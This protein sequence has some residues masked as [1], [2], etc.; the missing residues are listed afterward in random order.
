MRL[1]HSVSKFRSCDLLL[2]SLSALSFLTGCSET[3]TDGTP[4]LS[5][6]P[7]SFK[8][9]AIDGTPVAH[10]SS[11][12]A[13][14]SRGVAAAAISTASAPD[15]QSYF[16]APLKT[17]G[18]GHTLY[19]HPLVS[20]R[21]SGAMAE[22]VADEPLTRGTRIESI[23]Q[24]KQ[25]GVSAIPY[26]NDQAFA[27]A[28]PN[29]LFYNETATNASYG[30]KTAN[31]H[32]WPATDKVA[33]YAYAPIPSPSSNGLTLSSGSTAG[34]PYIDYALPATAENQPDLIVA[35]NK[36]L[37]LASVGTN[38]AVPLTFDHQLT[39]IRFVAG[40][41][42]PKGQI[43]SVG[44]TNIAT[45]GRLSLGGNWTTTA[46]GNYTIS[47]MSL[48]LT[49]SENQDIISGTKTLLMIPQS[50]T[51]DN[52][53]IAITYV[54]DNNTYNLT[55][56]LKGT[57]WDKGQSVVYKVSPHSVS[58]L[59]LGSITFATSWGSNYPK[60]AFAAGDA[61]GIYVADA[62]GLKYSN[63]KLTYSNGKWTSAS[64]VLLPENCR[65]YVYYPYSDKGLA[66]TGKAADDAA[67]F[68]AS[69]ISSWSPKTD[70][71]SAENLNASDLQ[72]AVG[73]VSTTTA[74]TVN[75][76]MSHQ[77]GLAVINLGQKTHYDYRHLST[78]ANFKW[79]HNQYTVTASSAIS[80]SITPYKKAST[81][82]VAIQK[83]A[84]T[85]VY[86]TTSTG[87][88][89]WTKT[90][91]YKLSADKYLAQEATC[92]P[93]NTETSYTMALGDVYYSDGDMSHQSESLISGKTPIGIVG[94]IGSNYWTE[95]NTK[96]SSVGGHALV[97]CLKTIGS[98]GTTNYGTSYQWKTSNTDDN[99]S[100]VNTSALIV[101]SSTQ[102]YGSGYKESVAL[103]NSA[104]PAA[105]AALAYTTLKAPSTSTGWFL[106]TAG[107]YY[108]IM[109]AIGDY[110]SSGW[111][112]SNFVSNMIM[113]DVTTKVNT[114]LS[115]VGANN[116]TEFFQANSTF[117]WTST[118]FSD[119]YAIDI[120]SGV[121]DGKG[122]GSVRFDYNTL[123]GRPVR[124]FL[125]F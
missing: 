119:T 12:S 95:K 18:G 97:M 60:T 41:D 116:Y 103:N 61:V 67:T 122:P 105:Q 118:R 23:G 11:A 26:A 54:F 91:S 82:Y 79:V 98:T 53:K 73:V 107:Q 63:I 44:F 81:C 113:I 36:G 75:F 20:E 78:D 115:K 87:E 96:S 2:L 30:W 40:P 4:V 68:F 16:A 117:E 93:N 25:F 29:S 65:F 124:P 100:K 111:N 45:K 47:N 94:Y 6:E 48:Q 9:D 43:T 88:D 19:L 46:T 27:S 38:K 112:I 37:T 51:T 1:R 64:R 101:G 110:P 17:T 102:S 8:V 49:G 92:S 42:M 66:N 99:R 28:T 39:S 5:S 114:A 31:E 13:K 109:N 59:Q 21:V 32:Y 69:G 71:S 10:S 62:N 35:T 77:M 52:Q 76:S 83:P 85:V 104:H 89:K 34:T 50:F 58:K 106:P 15:P 72:V 24:L 84:A 3:L 125:A 7:I 56:S 33:F 108:A 90:L 55:G 121:D 14:G 123:G 86:N 57:K 74:S 70:Q 120:D 80:A 22:K